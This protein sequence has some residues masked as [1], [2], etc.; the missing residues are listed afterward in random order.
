MVNNKNETIHHNVAS[1]EEIV[2]YTKVLKNKY[3]KILLFE[4]LYKVGSKNYTDTSIV[5]EY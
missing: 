3:K 1:I 5:V 4:N 2:Y